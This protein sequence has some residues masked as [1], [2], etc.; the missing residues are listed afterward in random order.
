[1]HVAIPPKSPPRAEP[2]LFDISVTPAAT[3]ARPC[4]SLR[5]ARAQ[6]EAEFGCVDWYQYQIKADEDK[7]VR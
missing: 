1:M 2:N 3:K 7:T 4:R 5:D 6:S